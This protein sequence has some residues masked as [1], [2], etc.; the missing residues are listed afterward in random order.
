MH[1]S[2]KSVFRHLRVQRV[3]SPMAA[4]EEL[5]LRGLLFAHQRDLDLL[6][7]LA[8]ETVLEVEHL[9]VVVACERAGGGDQCKG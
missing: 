9:G 3:L 5:Q 1:F 8:A 4:S 2:G 6:E 7:E